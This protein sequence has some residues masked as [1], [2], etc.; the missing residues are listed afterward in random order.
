MNHAID[1]N[2][3]LKTNSNT[4]EVGPKQDR[5]SHGVSCS[6][7]V[8]HSIR[9]GTSRMVRV[10]EVELVLGNSVTEE[11]KGAHGCPPDGPYSVAERRYVVQIY[12]L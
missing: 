6:E 1:Y 7:P 10:V 11:G 9:C 2:D 3:H 8:R 4:S 12:F 5:F